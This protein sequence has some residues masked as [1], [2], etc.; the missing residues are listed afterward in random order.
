MKTRNLLILIFMVISWGLYPAKRYRTNKNRV[1]RGK[2]KLIQR[3]MIKHNSN[4][5]IKDLQII[6][7]GLTKDIYKSLDY[8]ING[9]NIRRLESLNKELK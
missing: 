4:K 6:E 7:R 3:K 2:S 9:K 8:L 1:T 5:F